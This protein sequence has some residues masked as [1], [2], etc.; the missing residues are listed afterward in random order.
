MKKYFVHQI[1]FL[2]TLTSFLFSCKQ[3]QLRKFKKLVYD[4]SVDISSIKNGLNKE[5]YF[6]GTHHIGTENYYNNI[7]LALDSL[8]DQGFVLY[9]EG[10]K[11]DTKNLG[12]LKQ[13][14]ILKKYFK[15]TGDRK[16][17]FDKVSKNFKGLMKQPNGELMGKDSLDINADVSITDI[18]EYYESKFGVIKVNSNEEIDIYKTK[19]NVVSNFR[20]QNLFNHLVDSNY[21]KIMILY[22]EN[23]KPYLVKRLKKTCK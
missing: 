16:Y 1:F 7:K 10:I 15:I 20:N 13:R 17:D 9:Y 21:E 3:I 18:V 14:L 23:H 4:E 2:L 12:V 8:R 19:N 5:I 11:D 6:I 22:G